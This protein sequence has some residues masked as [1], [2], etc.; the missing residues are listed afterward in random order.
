MCLDKTMCC[1][2]GYFDKVCLCNQF[3]SFPLSFFTTLKASSNFKECSGEA[4][5]YVGP[6]YD[7][8]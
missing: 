4:W 6:S 7:P 2:K 8:K 5:F 3:C 1:L